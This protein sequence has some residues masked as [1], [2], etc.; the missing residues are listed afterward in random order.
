MKNWLSFLTEW[1]IENQRDLPWRKS[2]HPYN[3]WVSE[4]ILQQTRVDQALNYYH[5]FIQTFPDI[6]SLAAAS[7]DDVLRVWKGLGY[8][9]RALNMH[10]TANVIVSQHNGIF[11]KTYNEIIKLRGVGKYTAAA[12]ASISFNEKVYVIDGNVHRIF[13]R[14]YA[15]AFSKNDKSLEQLVEADAQLATKYYS[16]GDVN[17][18]MMEFGATICKPSEPLC[19]Q[20]VVS[21]MCAAYKKHMI[22]LFPIKTD[23]K[24]KKTL[25]YHYFFVHKNNYCYLYQRT[26]NNIWKNLYEFPLIVHL[27][28]TTIPLQKIPFLASL[29]I[30]NIYKYKTIR[31]ILSH[32][33]IVATLYNIEVD[34]LP[35]YGNFLIVSVQNIKQF[36]ISKLMDKLIDNLYFHLNNHN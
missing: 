33:I 28:D 34:E 7:V 31:H 29:N 5:N 17:Q 20:C 23:K 27:K 26:D 35:E 24:Q 12:I 10:E 4:V 18:A 36:P 25:Y 30:K 8:Y 11:P 2:Q 14:F 16:P 3:V 32:R 15:K 1:Y 6:Y 22:S 21:T 19:S 13:S 9:R